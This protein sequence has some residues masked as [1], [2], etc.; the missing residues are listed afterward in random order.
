[1]TYQASAIAATLGVGA[2]AVFATYYRFAM[3]MQDGT[4]FPWCARRPGG[5]G[6][7]ARSA[8]KRAWKRPG[9]GR[10]QERLADRSCSRAAP[11]NG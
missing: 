5:R 3:H 7:V 1:M 4:P 2:L 10:P 9:A 11:T 6:R 8:A